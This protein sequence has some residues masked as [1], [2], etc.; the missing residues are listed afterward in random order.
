[1]ITDLTDSE[2][3]DIYDDTIQS[4]DETQTTFT[5][6]QRKPEPEKE[7]L[8]IKEKLLI[9][10]ETNYGVSK[11]YNIAPT[12]LVSGFKQIV[13]E[14]TGVEETSQTNDKYA[15]SAATHARAPA[16]KEA[17]TP[18]FCCATREEGSC[19]DGFTQSWI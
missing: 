4:V 2:H 5:C 18:E 7:P 17:A 14:I 15:C 13:A 8:L 9:K 1:M 19:A 6:F 16:G 3:C 12:T 10:L 11:H